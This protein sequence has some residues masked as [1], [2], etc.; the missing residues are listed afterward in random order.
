M[1]KFSDR[2]LGKVRVW[3]KVRGFWGESV[4]LSGPGFKK[5]LYNSTQWSM[6]KM[7]KKRGLRNYCACTHGK[8]QLRKA[9][10]GRVCV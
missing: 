9:M 5:M 2:L 4:R 10:G 1:H 8:S 7:S 6:E 3:R